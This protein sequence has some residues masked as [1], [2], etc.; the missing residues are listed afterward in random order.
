MSPKAVGIAGTIVGCLTI[1]EIVS[2]KGTIG[3]IMVVVS[4]SYWLSYDR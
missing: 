1:A 2:W 3:L 4:L